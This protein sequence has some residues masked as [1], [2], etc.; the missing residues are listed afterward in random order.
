MRTALVI[1]AVVAALCSAQTALAQNS[2]YP[3]VPF[4]DWTGV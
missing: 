4:Y 2:Q 1:V 3:P